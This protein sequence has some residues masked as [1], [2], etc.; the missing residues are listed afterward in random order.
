MSKFNITLAVPAEALPAL[1]TDLSVY[2]AELVKVEQSEVGSRTGEDADHEG[3]GVHQPSPTWSPSTASRAASGRTTPR[4]PRCTTWPGPVP[5]DRRVL[6]LAGCLACAARS[7]RQRIARRGVPAPDQIGRWASFFA[8]RG[9]GGVLQRRHRATW[10]R[11]CSR[12]SIANTS[13]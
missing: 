5:D 6:P 13:A 3:G 9:A 11:M 10:K 12:P 4:P 2:C 7:R 8:G 1:M